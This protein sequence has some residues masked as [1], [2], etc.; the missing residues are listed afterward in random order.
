MHS[1]LIQIASQNQ[2]NSLRS[3]FPPLKWMRSQA[4]PR[5]IE[6]ESGNRDRGV[7]DSWLRHSEIT[8]VVELASRDEGTRQ[9]SLPIPARLASRN[10]VR[11]LA[12][13]G[14][15]GEGNM[16]TLYPLARLPSGQP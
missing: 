1:T 13:S 10:Q 11:S 9:R 15:A 5:Q 3:G 14:R 8:D 12:L 4:L 7:L 6:R 2:K 16:I